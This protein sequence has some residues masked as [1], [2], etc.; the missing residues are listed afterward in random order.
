MLLKANIGK[1]TLDQMI[2]NKDFIRRLVNELSIDTIKNSEK[3]MNNL[4][5]LISKVTSNDVTR[6][7]INGIVTYTDKNTGGI[8]RFASE[9]VDY[10][11]LSWQAF[12]GDINTFSYSNTKEAEGY[13]AEYELPQKV[14]ALQ[15]KYAFSN[16]SGKEGKRILELQGYDE[17]ESKWNSLTE[18]IEWIGTQVPQ[19]GTK[20]LDSSKPY[21]R[22][23]IYV[24]SSILTSHEY[25]AWH[26]AVHE[27]QIYGKVAK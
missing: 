7:E 21:K 6:E 13:Y 12:D 11:G 19:E 18:E 4:P 27:M 1:I 25:G 17:E 20:N 23:R 24:K 5:E 15:M 22:Y 9:N 10:K 2:T 3:L 14:Y 8:M 26:S 16:G